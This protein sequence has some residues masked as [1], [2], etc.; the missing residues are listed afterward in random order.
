MGRRHG[1]GSWHHVPSRGYVCHC[2]MGG[3]ELLSPGHP[4]SA[5]EDVSWRLPQLTGGS[6]CPLGFAPETKPSKG[7]WAGGRNPL[8]V[9]LGAPGKAQTTA[10]LPLYGTDAEA[11]APNI[12][13]RRA[14]VPAS[15]FPLTHY[16]LEKD[17]ELES[18]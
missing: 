7:P 18:E 1:A 16:F 12:P 13:P 8:E 15:C 4:L 10:R 14:P 11:I 2:V 6:F 3:H 9:C 5:P 17:E